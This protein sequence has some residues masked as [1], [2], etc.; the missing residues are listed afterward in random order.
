VGA[1]D[2]GAIEFGATAPAPA[3]VTVHA[4]A[5]FVSVRVT[6]GLRHV[7]VRLRAANVTRVTATALRQGRIV[8][9]A[10]HLGP[11]GGVVRLTLTTPRRGRLVVRIRA[12]GSGG[13]ALRVVSLRARP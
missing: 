3:P 6:R 10:A 8:A 13:G 1:P 5:R 2:I 7:F 9:K 4:R 11:A 12:R